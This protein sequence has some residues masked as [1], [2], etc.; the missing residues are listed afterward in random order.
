MNTNPEPAQKSNGA[1]APA[2]SP[3][4]MI[5]PPQYAQGFTGM[6]AE[7]FP[8][9]AR[10]VLAETPRHED[11]QIKPDGI[12]FMPGVWWRRQ[13]TRAFGAGG[14]ALAPRGP[15]RTVGNGVEYHGALYCM[16]RWVA[17][18]V[19]GCESNYMSHADMVESARTDCLSKC[20]KDLGMASELWEK[21]WREAWQREYAEQYEVQS[22]KNQ[23]KKQWRLRQRRAPRAANLMDGAVAPQGDSGQV[24]ANPA[25][26]VPASDDNGEAATDEAYE[27]IAG[28]FKRLKFTKGGAR[29]FLLGLFGVD[30]HTALSKDQVDTAYAILLAW[31]QPVKERV[32][33][34]LRAQGKLRGEAAA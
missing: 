8:E 9:A 32:I 31:D 34:E 5:A 2:A 1:P 17:E 18:A 28:Q 26:T 7:P 16:G 11:V 33:A 15:T 4:G 10:A 19:G 12:V 21:D 25:P 29:Q 14:W 23:G 27:A 20:C 13:L 24:S 3:T 6:A 30:K 22:G